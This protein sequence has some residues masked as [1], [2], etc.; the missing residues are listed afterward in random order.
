MDLNPSLPT[1]LLG[2]FLCSLAVPGAAQ[3]TW[4]VDAGGGAGSDYRTIAEAVA[5]ASQGDT[6]VVRSAGDILDVTIAK[7]LTLVSESATPVTLTAGLTITGIP[8]GRRMVVKGFVLRPSGPYYQGGRPIVCRGS[9]GTIHL[10]RIQ[11]GGSMDGPALRVE[12]CA[13]VTVGESQLDAGAT[14]YGWFGGMRFTGAG[15]GITCRNSALLL[16]RTRARGL[17]T[18]QG[19]A[20]GVW[21]G[22]WGGL[23]AEGSRV[24]VAESEVAGGAGACLLAGTFCFPTTWPT[25]AIEAR[26]S[27]LVLAGA[28]THYLGGGIVG[29]GCTT[30]GAPAQGVNADGATTIL[31]D[32]ASTGTIA[33]GQVT[34]Q[35]VAAMVASGAGPGG[36]A[37]CTLHWPQSAPC[38]TLVSFPGGPMPIDPI[39]IWLDPAMAIL[40]DVGTVAGSRTTQVPIP[41]FFP[42]GLP[43]AFQSVVLVQGALVLSTPATTVLW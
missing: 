15:P 13:Q 6:I 3:R 33:G 31:R 28:G 9:A 21:Y 14:Y 43:A 5:A 24:V 17:A 18:V 23:I 30:C 4:R 37:S 2:L 11:N 20:G 38:A 35:P 7:A 10:E 16:V 29:F 36:T 32:P 26:G 34:T 1:L 22:P 41:P 42:I 40:I 27:R 19:A 39:G 12:E 8:G 25:P